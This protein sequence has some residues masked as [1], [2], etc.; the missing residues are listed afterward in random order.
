MAKKYSIAEARAAVHQKRLKA[1]KGTF[2]VG[3]PHETLTCHGGR[4]SR[5]IRDR[6]GESRSLPSLREAAHLSL[7]GLFRV[8]QLAHLPAMRPR[9]GAPLDPVASGDSGRR[10]GGGGAVRPFFHDLVWS[11]A[12]SFAVTILVLGV[13]LWGGLWIGKV[14]KLEPP[15]EARKPATWSVNELER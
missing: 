13:P 4:N 2:E 8:A 5:G 11:F 7:S 15:L 12:A 9:R 6:R 3:L 14:M 10:A 1:K